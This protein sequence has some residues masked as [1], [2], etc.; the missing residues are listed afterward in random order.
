MN[1]DKGPGIVVRTVQLA[2]K[3][4]IRLEPPENVDPR[5]LYQLVNGQ[6]P[7]LKKWLSWVDMILSEEQARRLLEDARR[8]NLG[9]QQFIYF[10]FIETPDASSHA[11][12]AGSIAFNRIDRHNQSA[13]MGYWLRH[14]L[15]G[16]GII[17]NTAKHL[18]TIGFRAF[19]LNRI[20]IRTEKNNLRSQAVARKLGFTREGVLRK[21]L[22]HQNGFEDLLLFG[23]LQE[24]W[25]F[26]KKN[27]K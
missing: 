5:E 16:K 20:E 4:D 7:Y 25:D 26:D 21:A 1:R 3:P 19:K 17:L 9:G 10:I 13:Q 8:F 12:L 22:R 14:E 24:E 2:G 18:I 27:R 11:Y 15:Q 6:R 23:L